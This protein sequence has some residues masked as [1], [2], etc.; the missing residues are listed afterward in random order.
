[1]VAGRRRARLPSLDAL[2]VFEATARHLSFTKAAAELHVT[3]SAISHR[4]R[5]LEQ[6]L[7]QKLLRRSPSGIELTSAGMVLAKGVGRAVEEIW[8]AVDTV[9]NDSAANLLTLSVQSA[10]A[11]HW[12][13]PRLPRFCEKFPAI[14]LSISAED[15]VADL[16]SGSVDARIEYSLGGERG[17]HTTRLMTDSTIPVCSPAALRRFGPLRSPSEVAKVPLLH[18]RSAEQ[19]ASGSG[20]QTWLDGVG[21]P[22]LACRSGL[23][24]N[25]ASLTLNAAAAGLGLALARVSLLGSELREGRLVCPLPYAVRTHY[26]YNFV[27]LPEK[28]DA[29]KLRAF[30]AWLVE[31]A[32]ASPVEG[33][34]AELVP[35]VDG[36][37][38]AAAGLARVMPLPKL[39]AVPAAPRAASREAAAAPKLAK[40]S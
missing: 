17:L 38:H 25:D 11:R 9:D 32:K 13:M 3:Q 2:R 40:V 18:D 39:R 12:L 28:H 22:D 6:S 1:M 23:R 36:A 20:W 15:Q 16:L 8:S 31:E 7:G 10:F 26:A 30:L 33:Q 35:I 34:I 24:F 5:C 29:P 37:A 14:E 27:T 4:I 21:E 19:D